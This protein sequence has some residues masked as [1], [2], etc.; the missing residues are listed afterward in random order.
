MSSCSFARRA[1]RALIV[2]VVLLGSVGAAT[3]SAVT[4]RVD[5]DRANCPSAAFRSIPAALRFVG[6]GGTVV[7]C[8][9]TYFGPLRIARAGVRVIGLTGNAADVVV[10][11]NPG[12]P[13]SVPAVEMSAPG[14]TLAAVTVRDGV[15][16]PMCGAQLQV[17]V[18]NGVGPFARA[19]VIDHVMVRA[20]AAS[21]IGPCPVGDTSGIS[22]GGTAAGARPGR[23]VVRNSR[24]G[25]GGTSLRVGAGS[26]ASIHDNVVADRFANQAVGIAV[27]GT[28][29]VERNDIFGQATGI[30]A[31]GQ[32]TIGG[33]GRG[34][35]IHHHG[36]FGVFVGGDA[37]AVVANNA[38]HDNGNTGVV[39][40]SL[41]VVV[42][43]AIRRNGFGAGGPGI[44]LGVH[45]GIRVAGTGAV[46]ASNDVR[47]NFSGGI[48]VV[49]DA[50]A[51]R[52]LV[53]VAI[54][55]SNDS[56]NPLGDCFDPTT[57]TGTAGTA[58]IWI[59]NI[60]A[61]AFP[62]DICGPPAP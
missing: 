25:G 21:S 39:V 33:P 49:G 5:D 40:G 27:V 2:A 45:V 29:R 1:V 59:D 14:T 55:N 12:L 51:N 38:I 18:D 57:G 22:V 52:L 8:P 13:R 3:A 46:V 43:N 4:V 19:S 61:A 32:A 34:N 41:A 36:G 26:T 37:D 62:P 53:N 6:A 56:D 30:A 35:N 60:G 17:L 15:S 7:V 44:G 23:A 31:S 16:G 42:G 20:A 11:P 50:S 48:V 24:V 10:H 47:D 58:N 28:A 9:G 54:N